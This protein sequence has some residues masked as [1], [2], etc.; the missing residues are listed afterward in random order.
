MRVVLD[1]NILVSALLSTVGKP[2]I[3]CDAWEDGHFTLLSCAQQL[4]EIREALKIQR[5]AVRIK[6]HSAG[7]FISQIKSFAEHISPLP[8]VK[9][10]PDPDD[11][12]LLA[13]SE[14]GRADYFVTGDKHGLLSLRRHKGTQIVSAGK[15]AELVS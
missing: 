12:F 5:I 13:L 3:I 6:P 4:D 15:F 2:A 14:A 7:R 9:R 10:S 11:D 8:T 1:T